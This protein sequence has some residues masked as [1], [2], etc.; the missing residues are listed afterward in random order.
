MFWMTGAL[1]VNQV[2]VVRRITEAQIY[3]CSVNLRMYF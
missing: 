2:N 3:D 1:D